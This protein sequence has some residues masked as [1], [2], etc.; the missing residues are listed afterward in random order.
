MK[1]ID[2]LI[3]ALALIAVILLLGVVGTLQETPGDVWQIL[4]TMKIQLIAAGI[5]LIP[6]ILRGVTRW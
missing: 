6:A 2:L 5:L 4:T 1:K 3:G